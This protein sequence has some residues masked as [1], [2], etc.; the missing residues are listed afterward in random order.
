MHVASNTAQLLYK[1]DFMHAYMTLYVYCTILYI[2]TC[3]LYIFVKFSLVPRPFLQN[4]EICACAGGG[5]E[6]RRV[7]GNNYTLARIEAG[8]RGVRMQL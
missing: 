3:M 5:A 2:I 6:E 8:M 1:L 4:V 7:W